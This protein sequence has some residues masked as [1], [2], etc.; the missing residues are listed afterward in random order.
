MYNLFYGLFY[1]FFC[2]EKIMF[3]RLRFFTFLTKFY[4]FFYVKLFY[5]FYVYVYVYIFLNFLRFCK[6]KKT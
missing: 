2:Q 3:L 6:I 1:V 5:V 4:V